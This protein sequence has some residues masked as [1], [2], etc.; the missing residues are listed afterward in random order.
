MVGVTLCPDSVSFS[1]F[2]FTLAIYLH[3]NRGA[4]HALVVILDV[5]SDVRANRY[6]SGILCR[7]VFRG[8]GWRQVRNGFPQPVLGHNLPRPARCD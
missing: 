2:R 1:E 7:I 4:I 5:E 3:L 6:R 8:I